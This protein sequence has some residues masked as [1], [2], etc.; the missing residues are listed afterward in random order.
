MHDLKST[1]LA[2]RNKNS[3]PYNPITLKFN[4]SHEAATL[5]YEVSLSLSYV[6]LGLCA[7][8]AGDSGNDATRVKETNLNMH[9]TTKNSR[10]SIISGK[11]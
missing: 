6:Y 10:D 8:N 11:T 5:H 2:T 1:E 4:D 9:L 3:V 7:E